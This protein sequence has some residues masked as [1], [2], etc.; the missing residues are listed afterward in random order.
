[1]VSQQAGIALETCVVAKQINVRSL[2]DMAG[3][4]SRTLVCYRG[5]GRAK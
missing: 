2:I 5:S 4:K 3:A 1:M